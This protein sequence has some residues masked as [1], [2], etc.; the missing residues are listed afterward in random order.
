LFI[1]RNPG[2]PL[3]ESVGA[4][5]PVV[6]TAWLE[7]PVTEPASDDFSWLERVESATKLTNEH[8][9]G[10]SMT[11]NM[12]AKDR[13][14]ACDGEYIYLR[15]KKAH[16]GTLKRHEDFIARGDYKHIE[17]QDDV[18]IY[19]LQSGSPFFR[20]PVNLLELGFPQVRRAAIFAA[21]QYDFGLFIDALQELASRLKGAYHD[22]QAT[23]IYNECLEYVFRLIEMRGGPNRMII[24][25]EV[26]ALRT[27]RGDSRRSTLVLPAS[28]R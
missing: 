27:R 22:A 14:W 11:R 3:T 18:E 1:H 13:V 21:C 6:D 26:A 24:D 5:A 12:L 17:T 9:R 4:S 25:R 28:L 20:Q 8:A 7:E 15:R 16:E 23:M 2:K 19:K 10:K